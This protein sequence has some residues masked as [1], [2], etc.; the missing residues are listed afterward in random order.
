[1]KWITIVIILYLL[2]LLKYKTKII[3]PNACSFIM[4]T[5]YFLK[6]IRQQKSITKIN[7]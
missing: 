2:E 7:N 3:I 1:M 4:S 5:V 6:L